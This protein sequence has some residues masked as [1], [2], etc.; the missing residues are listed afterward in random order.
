MLTKRV[1]SVGQCFADQSA[2]S[3]TFRS[4]FGA[5]V[6]GADSAAEALG[7][8]ESEAFDLVLVNRIFDADGASG[9][10]FIRQLTQEPPRANVPVMLV[11]NHDWAQDEA[12]KAGARLG[13]GKSSLGQP[14]MLARV[15]EVLDEGV[16]VL[17]A[18]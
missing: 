14:Q 16:R 8:M 11:S 1:L 18:E 7:L 3:R 15:R 9:L 13:F 12:V 2:L 17:P 6:V 10:D 4:D 5:E